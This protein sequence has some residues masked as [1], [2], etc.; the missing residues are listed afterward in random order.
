MAA[1]NER[2]SLFIEGCLN[3]LFLSGKRPRYGYPRSPL[4]DAGDRTMLIK[5]A[6]NPTPRPISDAALPSPHRS[7]PNAA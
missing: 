3:D 7:S 1:E 2:R 5:T 4:P 6:Y